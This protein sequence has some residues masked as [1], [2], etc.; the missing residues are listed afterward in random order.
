LKYLELADKFLNKA[1][2]ENFRIG[3]S[4]LAGEIFSKY[5]K[6]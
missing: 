2:P 1:T 5:E 3:A 6:L 4:K